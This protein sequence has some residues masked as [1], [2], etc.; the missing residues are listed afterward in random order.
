MD[1][2]LI[3]VPT[4]NEARNIAELISGIMRFAPYVDILFVDDGS[5]DGTCDEIQLFQEKFPDKIHVKHR[6]YKMGLGSAYILGFQ[7]GLKHGYHF[8]FE[9][10]G[11]LSHQPQYLPSL[12]QKLKSV[13]FVIGS[14]YC[15]GGG[16]QN[17]GFF[18]RCLSRLGSWYARM[19][20]SLSIQDFTGGF[21]GWRAEVFQKVQLE[22][23]RSEGYSFQIELKYKAC[24]EGY[25]FSEIPI[26]FA[27]RVAGQSKMSYKI[28]LEAVFRVWKLRLR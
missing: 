9:M 17:W 3:V 22:G 16:T 10:D 26:I 21:N 18:R 23:I 6:P 2:T 20:L 25:R 1:K 8:L 13:D 27:E 19:V 28:I 14:R 24:Q 11:D 5:K 15:E 12:C 7:W 4:Y